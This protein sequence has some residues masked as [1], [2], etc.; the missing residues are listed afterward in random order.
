MLRARR[1]AESLASIDS[2]SPPLVSLRSL[3]SVG[4]HRHRDSGPRRVSTFDKSPHHER[5]CVPEA[6][7]DTTTIVSL[8]PAASIIETS[9]PTMSDVARRSPYRSHIVTPYNLQRPPEAWHGQRKADFREVKRELEQI[10]R[11][12]DATVGEDAD[13]DKSLF[14]LMPGAYKTTLRPSAAGHEA[15]THAVYL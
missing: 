12:V 2:C 5:R 3:G 11:S 1:R 9:A 6:L 15:T 4:S 14:S 7:S 8:V 10:D 13:T